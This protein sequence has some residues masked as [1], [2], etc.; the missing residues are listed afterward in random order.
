MSQSLAARDLG[1]SKE[2]KEMMGKMG[3]LAKMES[4]AEM[5]QIVFN[6][7]SKCIKS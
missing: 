1:D 6:Q 5:G 7:C 2:D 3:C 4:L